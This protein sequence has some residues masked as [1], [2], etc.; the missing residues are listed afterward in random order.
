MSIQTYYCDNPEQSSS[1]AGLLNLT[2]PGASTSTTGWTVGT[3]VAT[4]FSRM[5]FRTE[6]AAATFGTAVQPSAVPLGKAMDCWRTSAATT[7]SFSTG[8][9]YSS[10]SVIAVTNA[11]SQRGAALFRIWKSPNPDGSS[12]GSQLAS[13]NFTR[14]D[15]NPIAGNWTSGAATLGNLKIASNRLVG[16]A[17]GGVDQA[18]YYNAVTF[19]NDQFSEIRV[20]GG[21]SGVEVGGPMIGVMP[22]VNTYYVLECG[23]GATNRV[24]KL[25]GG[26]FTALQSISTTFGSGDSLT[27]ERIGS[28]LRAYKNRIQIGTDITDTSITTGIPGIYITGNS[29]F[30]VTAWA[31]GSPTLVELTK[32]RMTGSTLASGLLTTAAQS[33][34]A[35]TQIGTVTMNNDYLFMQVAWQTTTAATNANADVLVRLGSMAQTS[36][37]GLITADFTPAAGGGGGTPVS[38]QYYYSMMADWFNR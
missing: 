3:T 35:S 14:A 24:H 28:T 36:G 37:S 13:D 34:S 5:T 8:T 4:R 25:V 33:S 12:T 19:G 10:A 11:S 30:S 23:N 31:G 1:S 26:T 29:G 21:G 38:G 32:S 17:G 7:G 27:L 15:Q 16:A 9:W 18:A 20:E 6:K 2:Q 22:G